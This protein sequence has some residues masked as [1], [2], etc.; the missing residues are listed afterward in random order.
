MRRKKLSVLGE[1]CEF[2]DNFF[3]MNAQN[4]NKR[5]RRIHRKKLSALGEETYE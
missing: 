3:N 1:D 4:E 2:L 5:I